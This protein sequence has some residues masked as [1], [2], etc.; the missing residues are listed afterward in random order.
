MNPSYRRRGIG[1]SLL[2]YA[3]NV[4]VDRKLA[5]VRLLVRTT[6]TSAQNLYSK[7]GFTLSET[8][9]GQWLKPKEQ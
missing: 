9:F 5:G 3:K 1:E 7:T 8:M 6:N 4:C 2:E